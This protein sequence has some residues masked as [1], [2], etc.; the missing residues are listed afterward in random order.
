M[1]RVNSY[2]IK[3]PGRVSGPFSEGELETMF[4]AGTVSVATLCCR[5]QTNQWRELDEFFPTLKYRSGL[6]VDQDDKLHRS[7]AHTWYQAGTVG[8]ALIA[9][10]LLLFFLFQI[11]NQ[12]PKTEIAV[13]SNY[14]QSIQPKD[15]LPNQV[16]TSNLQ[17]KIYLKTNKKTSQSQAQNSPET[18]SEQPRF[19][20]TVYKTAAPSL[21]ERRRAKEFQTPIF[22]W[23]N[24]AYFG[25]PDVWYKITQDTP[26]A[27]YIQWYQSSKP[28]R[29]E[30]KTG[31]E[32]NN[33]TAIT[34][35]AGGSLIFVD[36]PRA[37]PGK[38]IFVV[39]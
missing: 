30:K 23:T 22:Q 2:H 8:A 24:M 6:R 38:R 33:Y 14:L 32:G 36:S 28:Q 31:F 19:P 35:V 18:V 13:N 11:I 15:I 37:T 34:G 25:G 7:P 1:E 27:L 26:A 29:Y 5:T 16:V 21:Y 39:D 20:D 12:K 17:Q 3:L 9:I 10:G 4:N